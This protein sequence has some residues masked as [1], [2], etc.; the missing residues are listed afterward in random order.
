[1]HASRKILRQP[2]QVQVQFIRQLKPLKG[3]R[4]RDTIDTDRVQ[5]TRSLKLLKELPLIP[6]WNLILALGGLSLIVFFASTEFLPDLDLKSLV[7]VF[8]A[9]ACVALYLVASIGLGMVLPS[10]YIKADANLPTRKRVLYIVEAMLGIVG[11]ITFVVAFFS[12]SKDASYWITV[13]GFTVACLALTCAALLLAKKDDAAG[14]GLEFAWIFT[15]TSLLHSV[16]WGGWSLFLPTLLFLWLRPR[17][18]SNS[19]ELLGLIVFP[20][21]L[22]IISLVIAIQSSE[23]RIFATV[24]AAAISVFYL[25]LLTGRPAL[26]PHLSVA[27]L[28]LSLPDKPATI[29]VSETGCAAFN[30]TVGHDLCKKSPDS[31]LG[32]I[33]DVRIVSRIGAQFLLHVLPKGSSSETSRSAEPTLWTRAVLRKQ[34]VIA[35]S[36]EYGTAKRASQ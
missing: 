21:V 23:R 19:E 29:I 13:G 12:S 16:L 18:L 24:V 14:S 11:L 30:A 6:L 4:R 8:A 7:A 27:L 15:K 9:L 32:V 28:G 10:L 22:A 26:L 3:N 1:M 34:D 20:A 25:G 17:D 36:Y 35:W 5:W 33:K 31:S 2:P